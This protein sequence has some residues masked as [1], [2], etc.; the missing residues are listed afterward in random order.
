M[1]KYIYGIKNSMY[2]ENES[3]KYF[4]SFITF[5]N[6]VFLQKY[7][8]NHIKKEFIK[9]Y[10]SDKY[11]DVYYD[12]FHEKQDIVLF[13][14]YNQIPSV[15]QFLPEK[16]IY[17]YPVIT[18]YNNNDGNYYQ[19]KPLD[20][21]FRQYEKYNNM[22]KFAK[23]ETR[24]TI[25]I[26]MISNYTFPE[27]YIC[28][29]LHKNDCYI[30]DKVNATDEMLISE[31]YH[32][33]EKNKNR[34]VFNSDKIELKLSEIQ[35]ISIL[36]E[37]TKQH[38]LNSFES[39]TLDK[40]TYLYHNTKNVDMTYM[41][42]FYSIYPTFNLAKFMF[43]NYE[44]DERWMCNTYILNKNIEVLN[45]VLDTFYNNNIVLGNVNKKNYSYYD[46]TNSSYKSFKNN[47]LFR[48][49]NSPKNVSDNKHICNLNFQIENNSK[50]VNNSGKRMLYLIIYK[51]MSYFDGN[52]PPHYYYVNFLK[53][54]GIEAFIY[55]MGYVLKN[56]DEY[57]YGSEFGCT[58]RDIAQK[59]INNIS[60]EKGECN[61]I[62]YF[63]DKNLCVKKRRKI[64]VK[65][66]PKRT[67]KHY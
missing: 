65:R 62:K 16:Y 15:F 61:K 58:D 57:H 64:T 7:E 39:D 40:G 56:G 11:F 26:Q 50:K 25:P 44:K 27:N 31:N 66:T 3:F 67:H 34:Y 46:P 63:P 30:M 32:I 21:S 10:K 51:T 38:L 28:L 43:Q 23:D 1:N 47:K 14:Y 55:N 9:F 2:D 18:F 59:F 37:I 35:F 54:Y 22:I 33:K 4:R 41:P 53:K 6:W 48:C 49:L 8:D 29:I 5:Y 42:M 52:A 17:Y 19:N 20:I 36:K 60:N 24:I 13:T 45:L 12:L